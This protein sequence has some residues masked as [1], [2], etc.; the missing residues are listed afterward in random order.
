ML[1]LAICDDDKAAR[2]RMAEILREWNIKDNTEIAIKQFSSPYALLEA[3][4]H[5]EP[6]DIFLLDILMP[7]MTGITLGEQLHNLLDDPLLVYLTSSEDFYPDAFRLYAFQYLLKPVRKSQLFEVMDK[8]LARCR[9]RG[10]NVF[11][12]KTA[13]GMIQIPLSQIVYVELLAHVCHFHLAN[14]QC[15]RSQYLR[16]SFD[17]FAA[18]LRKH[19]RFVKTHTAYVVNLSF[20]GRLTVNSL[21]LTNGIKLPVTRTF[22]EQVQQQYLEFALHGEDTL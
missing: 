4:S 15:L 11:P 5:G 19:N 21:L 22:A 2:E 20:A 17:S 18:P 14:G 12:L 10:T 3:V 1:I 8:A 9:K 13:D 7:E 6:F 16:T